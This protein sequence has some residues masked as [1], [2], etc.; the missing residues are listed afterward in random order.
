MSS[1]AAERIGFSRPG[2]QIISPCLL[3]LHCES[4]RTVT[5]R[6]LSLLFQGSAVSYLIP[7][8]AYCCHCPVFL[9][10][11]SLIDLGELQAS[12]GDDESVMDRKR[13][14]DHRQREICQAFSLAGE[15]AE[16]FQM[17]ICLKMGWTG[18][19]GHHEV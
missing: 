8:S 2:E 6:Y 15:A 5:P 14:Q 18:S 19:P 17:V 11:S 10:P 4:L 9:R 1:A 3:C 12:E 13:Q 7:Y 16:T